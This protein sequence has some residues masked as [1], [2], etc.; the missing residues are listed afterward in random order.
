MLAL[1]AGTGVAIAVSVDGVTMRRA[2]IPG[3]NGGAVNAVQSGSGTL[4]LT[5]RTVP[6]ATRP[7]AAAVSIESG[8]PA[9]LTL[10]DS[11]VFANKVDV[12]GGLYALAHDRAL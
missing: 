4:S 1:A 3:G 6:R 8:H 12:G 11:S 2:K 9:P 10:S 5:S 7:A